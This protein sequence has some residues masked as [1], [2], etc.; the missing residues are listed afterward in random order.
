M[1]NICVC[2]TAFVGGSSWRPLLSRGHGF[3]HSMRRPRATVAMRAGRKQPSKPK[4]PQGPPEGIVDGSEIEAI[5]A[6]FGVRKSR[7]GQMLDEEYNERRETGG[8]GDETSAFSFE[9]LVKTFG[10]DNLDRAEKVIFGAL[11]SLFIMFIAGGLA[12]SSLAYFK[13]VGKPAPEGWDNFVSDKVYG[14]FTPSLVIFFALSSLFGLYK[15]AQ[16]STGGTT[17][18]ESD[19]DV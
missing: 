15:Q 2:R 13:A 9:N 14:A 1:S 16:L 3:T 8:T 4:S 19:K 11:L 10:Q 5:A 6:K 12:I 17:Y 18:T 7:P